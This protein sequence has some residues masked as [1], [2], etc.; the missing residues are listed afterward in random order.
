[1]GCGKGLSVLKEANKEK[2]DTSKQTEHLLSEVAATKITR[3]TA[4]TPGT[5]T[6]NVITQYRTP[7]IYIY[8][9]IICLCKS[10]E[11]A[12]ISLYF[13]KKIGN[14]HRDLLKY[15]NIQRNT[16]YQANRVFIILIWYSSTLS[17]LSE[18]AVL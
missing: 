11:P 12:F 7:T 3:H 1:M 6:V 8:I 17:V 14:R 4:H 5:V 16:A 15:A 2:E 18:A 9:Y 10:F 13:A